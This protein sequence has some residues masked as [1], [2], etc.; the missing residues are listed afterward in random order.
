MLD[1]IARALAR[2]LAEAAGAWE[3]GGDLPVASLRASQRPE[4]GDFFS[5]AALEL[6]PRVGRKPREVAQAVADRLDLPATV[7][8]VEVAG[9][10]F[11]NF[12]LSRAWLEDALRQCLAEGP[13]YGRTAEGGGERVQVEFVS[14]NPVGP[15]HVGNVRGGPFGDVLA[16]L[17]AFTGHEVEREYYVNDSTDNTQYRLF[18]SSLRLRYLQ[19]LGE[20]IEYPEDHY[21]AEYVQEW[22]RE[23]VQEHGGALREVPDTPEGWVQFAGL[24]LPQVLEQIRTDLRDFGIEYDVWFSERELHASGGVQREIERL[25]ATGAAYERDGAV[26]LRT[27]EYG[28]DEDRVL[29]RSGAAAPTYIASDCAYAQDKLGRGFERLIYVLGPDHAGYVP[30]MQATFGAIGVPLNHVELILSQI[31]RFLRHGEP[32]RLSKRKGQ[33]IALRELLDEIGRDAARFHFLTRSMD[34]HMDFDIELAKEQSEEN[35]VYYV[36]Y[37]H[38]RTCGI[39]RKAEERGLH[40]ATESANLALLTHPA[41][42]AVLRKIADLPAEVLAAARQRA[43]HRLTTFARDLARLAHQF[44]GPCKVLDPEAPELSAARLA[45]VRG[46]QTVLATVCRLLGIAAPERM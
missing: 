17:L 35:P 44:Y 28:D 7:D 43:P 45:L 12:F 8:R 29:I 6:A 2:A 11:L 23:L 46:V 16:S 3:A 40:L 13:E 14:A 15:L 27:T 39:F 36:Q 32:V 19:E 33:V 9:P 31:V 18:G 21:Q 20:Q 26:W 22:A 41:E 38:T 34:A 1:E 5:S 37:A 10:G 4:Q 24:L 42:L 25:L 30:R